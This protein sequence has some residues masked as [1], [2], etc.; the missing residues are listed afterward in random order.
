MMFSPFTYEFSG[1]MIV[2]QGAQDIA[3]WTSSMADYHTQ[4]AA[5]LGDRAGD[6]FRMWWI[7]RMGHLP[8]SSYGVPARTSQV[9]EYLGI[10]E[11]AV[12]DLIAWVEDGVA[13]PSTT[14]YR[15]TNDNALEL[16][17][18]AAERGG[19]QPVVQLRVVAQDGNTVTFSARADVPR[20]AGTIVDIEWDPTG[21]GAWARGTWEHVHIYEQGGTHIAA[22]RVTSHR[23]GDRFD[24]FGRVQALGRARV[25]VPTAQ[26]VPLA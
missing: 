25:V 6:H 22:V 2:V 19:I 24:P 26:P 12:R 17:P 13:P 3:V 15:Y 20:G 18:T 21:T 9:I 10:I 4:V 14:A 1:K 11:Q 8:A 16:A 23:D 5:R 7:D